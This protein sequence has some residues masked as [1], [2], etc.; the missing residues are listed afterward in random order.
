MPNERGR[1]LCESHD[2]SALLNNA[3]AYNTDQ[4]NSKP[5]GPD[6]VEK[7]ELKRKWGKT[8]KLLI[9]LH[10][11]AGRFVVSNYLHTIVLRFSAYHHTAGVIS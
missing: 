7:S 2:V 9:Y 6:I 8:V 11:L 1:L 5:I 4:S 10:T 3:W